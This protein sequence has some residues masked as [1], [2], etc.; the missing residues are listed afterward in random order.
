MSALL[1]HA[2]DQPLTVVCA[3]AG[4]GKTTALADWCRRRDGDGAW[5]SLDDKDNDPRRFCARL[6]A[7]IDDLSPSELWMAEQALAG[8]SDLVET[9][10]P[11][12]VDALGDRRGA[13]AAVIVLDDYHA[14]FEEACHQLVVA[15]LDAL[16]PGV[17]LVL[18]SRTRPPLRLP[19]RRAA[20]AAA[21]LDARE[22]AFDLD[23]TGRLLNGRLRLRLERG[24]VEAIHA[25]V[26]GW[27]AGLSL[28][29]SLRDATALER[30]L[31]TPE[32]TPFEIAEYL[33]E[34]VLD[35]LP[36]STRV[37]LR[38]TSPLTRMNGA[39][40]A[41]VLDD[42]A[43]RQL[44]DDVRESNVF[45]IPLDDDWVRYH[46]LFATLLERDLRRHEPTIVV[47]LHRRAARWFEC[48]GMTEA[49]I[50]HASAAGDGEHAARLLHGSW[51]PLFAERRYTTIRRTLARMPPDRGRYAPFCDAIDVLCLS[52]TGGDLRLIARRLEQLDQD[53]DSPGVAEIVDLLRIS[54]YYGDI[55]RALA[56]GWKIWGRAAGDVDARARYAGKLAI[57]MWFAGEREAIRREVEPYMRIADRPVVRCWELAA[58]ALTAADEDDLETAE[59]HARDAV[60]VIEAAGGESSL[61]SHLAY[62]ALGEAL[63]RRGR[64]AEAHDHVARALRITSRHPSA[65]YHGL[66]LVMHAQLDLST[67]DR[68]A[69]RSRAKA[70]RRIVD[71][72]RDVG[73]VAE[74][75]AAVEDAL[76][77]PTHEAVAG[78][79]PTAAERRVLE[80]LPTD[81]T[82]RQIAAELRLSV[83]T[84]KSHTWRL[85]R[86]LGVDTRADAVS[87][88]REQGLV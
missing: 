9:V 62:L 55:E 12:A 3:P 86:R 18:A 8:G 23:E 11:L 34:E 65:L 50:D 73:V 63:R 28:V 16:P 2:L 29:A 31:E 42:P 6:L 41:A 67:L 76:D 61:E 70:A 44:F 30:F 4:Y 46:R 47:Q 77:L 58:L 78:S 32:R 27:P 21:T 45:V 71:R 83:S 22:L 15:L 64:F 51:W 56:D 38:R 68:R 19:R 26:E 60:A 37:F 85:Y 81:L 39:L 75:L 57:V 54:P 52:L 5:L 33:T 87:I 24:Q 69:A 40:C 48:E 79:E 88:A 49:A 80:L 10:I 7:T 13:A 1:D 72:F 25:R 14:I 74:R 43:A 59:Q 53:R 35:A 17:R 36:P 84:V 20:G 82:R 66:A